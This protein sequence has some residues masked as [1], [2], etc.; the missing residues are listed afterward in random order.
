MLTAEEAMSRVG[1]EYDPNAEYAGITKADMERSMRDT[2]P[3]LVGNPIYG[4]YRE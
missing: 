3:G 4:F 1:A 2:L